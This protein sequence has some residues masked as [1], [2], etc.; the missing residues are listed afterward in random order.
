[1]FLN[2]ISDKLVFNFLSKIDYGYLEIKTFDGE[3]LKFGNQEEPLSA[4]IIIKKPNFNY[5]LISGGSVGFA[6]RY[7]SGEL[8]TNDV[9]M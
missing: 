9:S 1:M 4:N 6:E 3:L 8:A 5:N 7:M 2:K